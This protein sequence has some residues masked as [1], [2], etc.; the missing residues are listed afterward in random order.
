M[1]DVHWNAAYWASYDWSQKGDEWSATWGSTSAQWFGSILP[2]IRSFVPTGTILEIAPGFGRWTQ[3]LGA[4]CSR[5]YGVDISAN[6]A[7]HC[8]QRFSV[9]H[10]EFF[11]NE[12]TDLSMISDGSIDF[13]FS[14]DSLVHVDAIVMEAYASQIVSKLTPK[15]AA[16]IHHSNLAALVSPTEETYGRDPNVSASIVRDFVDGADGQIL[17][18]EIVKWGT[19]E[20][21]DCL[22]LFSK[23]ESYNAKP[24]I[25]T[26]DAF[27]NEAFYIGTN[28]APWEF[29]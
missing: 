10:M 1:P 23:R 18:Q 21:L 24:Q 15:G 29:R 4:M 26:N 2:R 20:G 22:S 28:I 14:F 17:R 6:C 16:F 13:V 25:A 9:P 3:F 11:A 5:Y 12:G 27:M 8:R 7:E 19:V